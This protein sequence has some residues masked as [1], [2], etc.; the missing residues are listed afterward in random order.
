MTQT[1]E[2]S[3]PFTSGYAPVNG[4]SMY[5]EI[6]GPDTGMPLVLI[7]GGGSTI[8]TNFSHI[9]PLLS[10]H[11]RVIAMELQVH[12]HTADR[13][14]PSSFQQDADDVAALLSE[15]KISKADVMGFSNGGSTAMQLAIRHP[16]L[17]NR[18]VFL[19][20]FYQREGL[21]PQFWEFMKKGTYADMPQI[22]KDAFLKVAPKPEQLMNM[23]KKDSGRM[24]GF[25]D[26]TDEAIRSIKI[27][28]M[29]MI[30]NEDVVMPE[31][32]VKMARL[33][34]LGQVVIV[35]GA[36]GRC[37]GEALNWKESDSAM[38]KGVVAMMEE[39]FDAK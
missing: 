33:M 16:E 8:E 30:S 19:S 23:F 3:R 1:E 20:A 10:Q 37:I 11:R 9:L 38:V 13:D 26:W 29:V 7:H 12:G 14:A 32:A 4:L 31:H 39:F 6:H 15:L 24:L 25:T 5:Y 22:Y 2:M 27:P 17:L 36:H 18:A 35:P 34:P 21:Y 28:A